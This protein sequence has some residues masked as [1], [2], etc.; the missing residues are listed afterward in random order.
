[1]R[2][3]TLALAVLRALR[4]RHR[5]VRVRG[6]SSPSA[7]HHPVRLMSHG[8]HAYGGGAVTSVMLALAELSSTKPEK[9]PLERFVP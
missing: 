2:A 7:A 5:V 1:M 4:A 9:E 6:V 8:R 3:Q